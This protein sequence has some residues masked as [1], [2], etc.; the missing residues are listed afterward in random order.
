M[1]NPPRRTS[2]GP[3]LQDDLTEALTTAFFEEL[4]AVGYGRLSIEAVARRAGAG[5]AAVYRR[6][7]SKQAMATD[8]I[9]KVAVDAA[10][11]PD[12]G[13]LRGDLH[14]FLTAAA[15][16]LRHPLAS[17]I[18]PDLL[19]EA[20]REPALAATLTTGIA[21][22]RR[23]RATTL[24]HRAITRGELPDDLDIPL[25]LDFLA[26]PLYWRLTITGIPPEPTYLDNLTTM[27]LTAFRANPFPT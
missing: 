21:T 22:T 18:I 14:A 4:A 15:A 13:S 11:T 9:T 10:D 20:A 2:G 16:G 12:T 5:K 6:W 19:A 25:A 27:L 8:L 7:P 1:P 24:L 23:D 17:K 26:G 3:V